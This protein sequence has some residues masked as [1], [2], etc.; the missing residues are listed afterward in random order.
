M[1]GFHRLKM[2]KSWKV[3]GLARRSGFVEAIKLGLGAVSVEE[4]N[5]NKPNLV[6]ASWPKD[7]MFD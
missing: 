3:K 4:G 5:G 6:I 7:G 1:V 2:D